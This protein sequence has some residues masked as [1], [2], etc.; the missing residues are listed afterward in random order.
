MVSQGSK[1]TMQHRPEAARPFLTVS[2]VTKYYLYTIGDV[3]YNLGEGIQTS[4]L[5]RMSVKNT[6][7]ISNNLWSHISSLYKLKKGILTC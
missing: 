3:S 1:R 5:D 2:E 7:A 6:W 4:I